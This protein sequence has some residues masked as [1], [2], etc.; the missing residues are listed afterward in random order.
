MA[1]REARIDGEKI[2]DEQRRAAV[3]WAKDK[4]STEVLRLNIG[5][6]SITH[7]IYRAGVALREAVRAGLLK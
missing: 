6:K 7:T 2:T 3:R 5:G 4:M 1:L